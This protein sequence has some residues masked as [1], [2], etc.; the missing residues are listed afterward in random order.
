MEWLLHHTMQ[1]EFYTKFMEANLFIKIGL[2]TFEWLI[3]WHVQILQK[4]EHMWL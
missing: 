3:L 4:M 2:T 1:L